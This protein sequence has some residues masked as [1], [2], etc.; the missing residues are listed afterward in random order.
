MSVWSLSDTSHVSY[1]AEPWAQSPP[2]V[3]LSHVKGDSGMWDTGNTAGLD[4][5]L[6][7]GLGISSSRSSKSD[8]CLESVGRSPFELGP[9]RL[10]H[11]KVAGFPWLVETNWWLLTFLKDLSFQLFFLSNNELAQPYIKPVSGRQGSLLEELGWQ[12][13]GSRALIS[14]LCYS[15]PSSHSPNDASAGALLP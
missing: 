15:F 10:S 7:P 2:Q 4:R 9:S 1:C 13:L 11:L 5:D 12:G 6:S 8:T 3:F 14:S